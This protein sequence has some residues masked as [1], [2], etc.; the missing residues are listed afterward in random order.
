M[1]TTAAVAGSGITKFNRVCSTV[2]NDGTPK[3][4][5]KPYGDN[6]VNERLN[7]IKNALIDT[8][9]KHKGEYSSNVSKSFKHIYPAKQ[10]SK[11]SVVPIKNNCHIKRYLYDTKSGFNKALELFNRSRC[12]HISGK[13][14]TKGPFFECKGAIRVSQRMCSRCYD[15][16]KLATKTDFYYVDLTERVQNRT[17]LCQG[18]LGFMLK[19]EVGCNDK[20]IKQKLNFLKSEQ[21]DSITFLQINHTHHL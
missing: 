18:C 17:I 8:S 13:W 20:E 10:G 6:K 5:R 7:K 1:N 19:E 4:R 9:V 21:S 12:F 15:S 3:T 14:L 16:N 2:T 11:M